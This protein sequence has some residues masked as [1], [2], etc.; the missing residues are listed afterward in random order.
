MTKT[1][2]MCCSTNVAGPPKQSVAFPCGVCDANVGQNSILCGGCARWVHK[3]CTN[4]KS[5]LRADPSFRCSRCNGM[6]PPPPMSKLVDKVECGEESLEVVR[7]FCYLGDTV[8]Q[9]G[10]C[11]D[12][13]NSRIQ[14]SWKAFRSLLPILTNRS[15]NL[16][17]RGH[18][19]NS[20]I[21][22][23]LLYAS[24]TWAVTTSDVS[25]L[26]RNFNSMIRWIC[27]VTLLDHTPSAELVSRLGL[28]GLSETLRWHRL[29]L[30]GHLL[31][32]P[33]N[34]PSS[35]LSFD[36]DAPYPRGRPKQRWMSLVMI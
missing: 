25:R 15:I 23:V 4:I 2:V 34:W 5:R 27:G 28:Y 30:Y 19:F 20:C 33:D 22:S 29:R 12:A 31:R 6:C 26:Q 1:K 21:L 11:L 7:T 32:H 17:I 16:K 8:G 14:S 9:T 24:E 36:V 3:R 18:V 13:I 35:A 10:G